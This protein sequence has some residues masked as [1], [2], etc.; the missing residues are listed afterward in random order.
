[1]AKYYNTNNE[2]GAVLQQSRQT[3][4]AQRQRVL[5]IFERFYADKFSPERICL[6]Y[7]KFY[8]EEIDLN[9]C[10][11]TITGLTKE[12]LLIKLGEED[13]V[14]GSKGKKIHRWKLAI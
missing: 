4:K 13:K 1:M 8:G 11:R 14:M 5:S 10:R 12:G 7:K 2:T 6:G 9:S 3:A